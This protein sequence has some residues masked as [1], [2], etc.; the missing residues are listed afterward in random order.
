MRIIPR[1]AE[2]NFLERKIK[3]KAG[4]V[5]NRFYCT[6]RVAFLLLQTQIN[7]HRFQ[8]HSG[9]VYSNLQL[10]SQFN[11]EIKCLCLKRSVGSS[12]KSIKLINAHSPFI[13]N[14]LS[15]PDIRMYL[16]TWSHFLVRWWINEKYDRWPG[17]IN[18][19][20]REN[21]LVLEDESP[22]WDHVKWLPPVACN[23]H[24]P[25]FSAGGSLE[26]RSTSRSTWLW[27]VARINSESQLFQSLELE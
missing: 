24:H 6:L 22:I 18:P 19:H 9:I 26:F 14:S 1:I 10:P 4:T 25:W 8:K 12:V 23:A 20:L 7:F 16:Q 3:W 2:Q 5:C 13:Q 15:W 27:K 21:S 11:F 17:L